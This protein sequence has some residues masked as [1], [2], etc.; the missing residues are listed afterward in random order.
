[1]VSGGGAAVTT[2]TTNNASHFQQASLGFLY[3]EIV[4]DSLTG[5]FVDSAGTVLFTRTVVKPS[6]SQ[7]R[8]RARNR[9]SRASFAIASASSDS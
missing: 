2:L 4:G 1:L 9:A 6:A 7:A 5:Q 8:S 3:V